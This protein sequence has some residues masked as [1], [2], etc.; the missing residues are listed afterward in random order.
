MGDRH[1]VEVDQVASAEMLGVGAC[2]LACFLEDFA[3]GRGEGDAKTRAHLLGVDEEPR[4]RRRVV[5]RHQRAWLLEGPRDDEHA[6]LLLRQRLGREIVF[7][8]PRHPSSV[9][10]EDLAG[11][12]HSERGDKI[13]ASLLSRRDEPAAVSCC[14][15]G[16]RGARTNIHRVVVQVDPLQADPVVVCNLPIRKGFS[17]GRVS[18]PLFQAVSP[19]LNK[20][21]L[22][23][24]ALQLPCSKI[25]RQRSTPCKE[26]PP[27]PSC[28]VPL[29]LLPPVFR[30]LRRGAQ[31][32]LVC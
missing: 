18:K 30:T 24:I 27:Q 8:A 6:D 16:R 4:P 22:P 25:H 7:D 11:F 21:N 19:L 32:L 15:A 20:L 2:R 29:L 10:E 14:A 31:Q 9:E 17:R 28:C 1:N 13:V 23:R 26:K 5:L 3:E 12:A